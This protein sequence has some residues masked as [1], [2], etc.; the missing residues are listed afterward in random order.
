MFGDIEEIRLVGSL[1]AE[2]TVDFAVGIMAALEV[3][4]ELEAEFAAFVGLG[5]VAAQLVV[6]G[7]H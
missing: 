7:A 6:F 4:L 1:V 3:E 5:V 2:D